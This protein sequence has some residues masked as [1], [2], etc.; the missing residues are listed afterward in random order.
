MHD[1]FKP[2]AE[3]FLPWNKTLYMEADRLKPGLQTRGNKEK[4]G[5]PSF[6]RSEKEAFGEQGKGM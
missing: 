3:P 2:V 1:K 4:V 6:S 5:S